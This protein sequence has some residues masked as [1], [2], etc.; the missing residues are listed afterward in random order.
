M[1]AVLHEY[2]LLKSSP[3]RGLCP[4]RNHAPREKREA[5]SARA[6]EERA[7]Q[8]CTPR[9]VGRYPSLHLQK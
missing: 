3:P 5:P 2:L 8:V 9:G 4:E 7:P 6:P 1:L